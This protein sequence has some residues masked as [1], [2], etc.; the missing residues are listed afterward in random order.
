[1][2]KPL[3][4]PFGADAALRLALALLLWISPT[5]LLSGAALASSELWGALAEGASPQPRLDRVVA[6]ATP[7]VPL[8]AA[9][10]ANSGGGSVAVINTA[11]N[12]LAATVPVGAG[13][14]SVAIHPTGT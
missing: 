3:R 13:P 7:A 12:A 9:Y 2:R 4:K 1:M 6:Q 5:A 14:Q 11:N 10:V 8:R